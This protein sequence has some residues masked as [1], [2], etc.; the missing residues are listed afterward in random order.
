M[1]KAI[2]ATA[3]ASALMGSASVALADSYIG[4]DYQGFTYS[5]TGVGDLKPQAAGFRFGSS[6]GQ[7]ARAEARLGTWVQ[8]AS[9]AASTPEQTER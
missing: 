5:A 2:L 9:E 3:M 1:K 6:L 7:Y 4:L 8:H